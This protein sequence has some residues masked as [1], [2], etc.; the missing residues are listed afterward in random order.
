VVDGISRTVS[1][2]ADY[3]WAHGYT[4]EHAPARGQALAPAPATPAT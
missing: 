2:K 1:G 3:S 4:R